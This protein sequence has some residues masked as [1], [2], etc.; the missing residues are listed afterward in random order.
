MTFEN[1]QPLKGGMIRENVEF[2]T[3]QEAA[4]YSGAKYNC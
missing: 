1:D 4:V 2:P 3:I